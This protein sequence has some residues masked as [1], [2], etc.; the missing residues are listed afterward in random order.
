MSTEQ[1]N[2]VQKKSVKNEV[3]EKKKLKNFE[4]RARKKRKKKLYPNC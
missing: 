1:Q 3:G 4:L 2:C